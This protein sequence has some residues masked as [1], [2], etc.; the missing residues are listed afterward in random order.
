MV[1]ELMKPPTIGPR[2]GPTKGAPVKTVMGIR[3]W[4]GWNKST[5]VPA[6]IL[7]NA[8]PDTPPRNRA[9][10]SVCIFCATAHGISQIKK[11]A[12]EVMYIGL[13]P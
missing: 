11:N 1:N 2:A 3:I 8:L 6:A 10:K 7:R 12:V 9:T 13:R 5:I 4:G